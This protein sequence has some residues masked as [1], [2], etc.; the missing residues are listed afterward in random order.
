MKAP[1]PSWV[2]WSTVAAVRATA[3][4][5]RLSWAEAVQT[6]DAEDTP[7]GLIQLCPQ[8]GARARTPLTTGLLDQLRARHPR[9]RFRLHA[10]HRLHQA[11]AIAY[12][13]STV[14][15]HWDS[16]F[17]PLARLHRHL[18]ADVYS[19]H[20]G[21]CSQASR[22]ELARGVARLE[23]LF[24]SPVAVEGLYPS[25]REALHIST[26]EGYR[27][28][29]DSGLFMAIDLSHLHI[30]R[31]VEG[32]FDLGLLDALLQSGRCLEVHLSHNNGR[33]DQH[34]DLSAAPPWWW[35]AVVRAVRERPGLPV[36]CESLAARV[37]PS[38]QLS[39][40]MDAH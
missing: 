20:A 28:L 25:R 7:T 35:E 30:V 3:A 10:N 14:A 33:A 37:Q 32:D 2:D 19:L 13:A 31:T 4:L 39:T 1:G 16:C 36:L 38:L 23:T 21:R 34:R 18:E 29:L 6:I 26:S 22:T 17:E 12:D 5:P 15:A 8:N 40:N 9:R 24:G 11:P 27:W